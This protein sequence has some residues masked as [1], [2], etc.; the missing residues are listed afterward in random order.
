M[1]PKK[2]TDAVPVP[3]FLTRGAHEQR[4]KGYTKIYK[5]TV[6]KEKNGE[7][8]DVKSPN[9]VKGKNKIS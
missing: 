7:K 9:S 8:H 1:R 5:I 4:K 6:G 3:M 2:K